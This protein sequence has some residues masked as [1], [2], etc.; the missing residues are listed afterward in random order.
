MNQDP[1][2][3]RVRER[4]D[5]EREQLAEEIADRLDAP[6]SALGVI[7]LL[8]VLAETVVSLEGTVATVFQLASWAIIA[9]FV[10]EFGVRLYVAPSRSRFMRRN[11]WQLVFLALPFLR[12]I[13][14]LRAVRVLRLLRAGRIMSSAVR[15]TRT[16]QR[17]LSGRIA[18]LTTVTAIVI[19]S[20]S[21]LLYE[22][23]DVASYPEALYRTAMAAIAG[24]PTSIAGFGQVLDVMLAAFS[25]VVFATLAASVGAYLLERGTQAP[26]VEEGG[27]GV[28]AG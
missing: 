26:N 17:R 3:P 4:P 22:M 28:V 10:A 16:A 8:L 5:Q 6:M 20:T 2:P 23:G 13:R 27:D 11:W 19:L 21:Q 24:Q 7:F 1:S 14:A 9:A 25:V 18:W 15:A 12:I